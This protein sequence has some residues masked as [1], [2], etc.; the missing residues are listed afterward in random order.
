LELVGLPGSIEDQKIKLWWQMKA[1][2]RNLE[3]ILSKFSHHNMIT[4]DIYL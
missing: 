2:F 1:V 3:A 4:E